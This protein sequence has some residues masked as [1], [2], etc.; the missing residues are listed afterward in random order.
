MAKVIL[1]NVSKKYETEETIKNINLEIHDKEFLILVGP[2][3]C[4][5]STILRMIAG[6]ED[7][8]DGEIFIGEKFV[9]NVE[10]KDRN[11]AMVFQSYALYPHMNVYDNMAFGLKMR[12]FSKNDIDTKVKQAAEILHITEFLD[13][14]P[15]Q[16]SG[17]QRQRVALGRAIVRDPHVF[18]MDEPLSNLDAKL[19][20]QMRSELIKLHHELQSTFIYVTHDQVEA[21]TMGDRIVIVNDGTIQQVDTPTNIYNK[22]ANMFVASFIGSPAMNFIKGTFDNNNLLNIADQKIELNNDKIKL[23]QRNNC[24]NKEIIFGIRPENLS[25]FTNQKPSI[26]ASINLVEMLGSEKLVHFSINDTSVIAKTSSDQEIIKDNNYEISIEL[27]K[28]VFFNPET[29]LKLE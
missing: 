14:K 26:S 3:G 11:I 25:L 24:S 17:G 7:V 12:K 18:L 1:K 9:N 29:K 4:G 23:L 22:P 28:A 21:M 8:T 13:K 19:R 10:P 5:K 6:L 15:R 27:D 16:L 2:S 20:V